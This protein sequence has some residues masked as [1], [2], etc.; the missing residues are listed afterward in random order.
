M[1]L[2]SAVLF[3]LVLS[4]CVGGSASAESRVD[5]FLGAWAFKLPDGNPAWLKLTREDQQ[6]TGALLWSVGSARPVSDVTIRDGKLT[7]R[8]KISWRPYGEPTVK[9]VISPF[10]GVVTDGGLRLSFTQVTAD[11]DDGQPEE[12]ALVGKRVPP[13]PS[14][15]DLS[16]VR[17][18]PPIE[19]LNGRDLAGWELSNPRK[20]NG[21]SV[22]DGVLVNE[23][24][25][26]DFGAYGEYGNLMTE[27]RFTDFELTIEYNVALGGNSGIYLR[28][29]YEAQVVDR[30]SRMQGIQGPGAIFGRIKP[31]KNAARPGGEWNTYVLTLVDRHITVVLNGEK[32]IDNQLLEGCTGGGLQADDT[33]PG[34]IFLQGDHT[35]VR[36]RNIRLRPVK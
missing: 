36:Y 21:W 8:R 32:V 10:R 35:A 14:R 33:Q 15:P 5:A 18:G 29:M 20:K 1:R 11:V 31:S 13:A 4:L 3:V 28:G 26:Q 24:P 23:T 27:R 22:K 34:P 19:L 25:K 9:R 7:F 6:L 17:F 30:D 16:K 12:L 2:R